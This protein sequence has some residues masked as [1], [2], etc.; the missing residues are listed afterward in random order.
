MRP[1]GRPWRRLEDKI[2]MDLKEVDINTRNW[3]D[4][5]QDKVY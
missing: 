1:L 4:L 2:R 3:V 5:T